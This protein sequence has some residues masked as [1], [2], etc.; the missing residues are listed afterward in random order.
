MGIGTGLAANRC[1]WPTG[2]VMGS[3]AEDCLGVVLDRVCTS[4]AW[5]AGV[6]ECCRAWGFSSMG[7][8]DSGAWATEPCLHVGNSVMVLRNLF[9]D[10]QVSSICFITFFK[11][12][13]V[14]VLVWHPDGSGHYTVK[15]GYRLLWTAQTVSQGGS[16]DTQAM[17]VSKFYIEM[18]VVALLAKVVLMVSIWVVWSTRNKPM[19]VVS[20]EIGRDSTG[21]VLV[22]CIIPH[23][24]VK[25]A[26]VAEEFSFVDGSF[27]APIICDINEISKAFECVSFSF[28]G[29]TTTNSTHVLAPEGWMHNEQ[30]F[31]VEEAPP[32]G[33]VAAEEDSERLNLS[34]LCLSR[35]DITCSLLR[36]KSRD[37]KR[38]Q[39]RGFRIASAP[40]GA[41]MG[42]ILAGSGRV[43]IYK[44]VPVVGGGRVLQTALSKILDLLLRKS[45]DAAL[46]FIADQKQ[47]FEQLKEWKSFDPSSPDVNGMNLLQVTLKEKLYGK[48]LLL[49]LDDFLE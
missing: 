32:G 19:E 33:T 34:Y 44:V 11:A 38:V 6:L 43:W 12:G 27:I 16:L 42:I 7:T 46:N 36:A 41:G 18:W 30:R 9:D 17:G 31:W 3:R 29:R 10:E 39:F 40:I 4:R 28:V 5:A 20:G 35:K 37:G 45:I 49:V 22:S 48:K 13:M 15:S 26:F 8:G 47:V 23:T 21:C 14:D 24:F 2:M 25:D 1:R